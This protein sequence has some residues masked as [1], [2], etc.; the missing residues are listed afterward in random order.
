MNICVI[1][2]DYPSKKTSVFS[3]VKELVD[4]FAHQ[5]HSVYVI[6]PFSVTRNKCF[7]KT[8][9][10]FEFESGGKVFLIRPM[11]FS[12]STFKIGN[13]SLTSCLYKKAIKKGFSLLPIKPDIIY[14]HFWSSAYEGYEFAKKNNIPLFVATGECSFDEKNVPLKNDVAFHNYVSGVVC[15]SSKNKKMSLEMGL[16]TEEK[17]LV[18]PNAINNSSFYKMDKRN[19]REKYGFPQKAFI[20]AF[21]GWFDDRKGSKRLS[22]AIKEI[23]NLNIYSIFIGNGSEEPDCDNILFKGNVKHEEICS[24]LNCADIFVL[25]TLAEGCCNAIIEAMACGIPIVSS[26]CDFNDDILDETNSLRV[27][28][29]SVEEIA[30]AIKRLYEDKNLRLSLGKGALAKSATLSI[31]KRARI[32]CKFIEKRIGDCI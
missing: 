8:I 1:S 24:L 21:I 20:V 29:T 6:S 13:F 16:T 4:E 17:C 23:N 32:I 18:V 2:I 22:N 15:V 31:E 3:F 12:F 28:P 30:T 27:N 7:N 19:V 25:P 11:F 26:N 5:G 9:D 10:V 14:G